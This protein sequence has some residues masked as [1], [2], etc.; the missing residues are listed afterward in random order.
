MYRYVLCAWENIYVR[1][2]YGLLLF[3]CGRMLFTNDIWGSG[4]AVIGLTLLFLL[5]FGLPT[6]VAYNAT[7]AHL[8]KHNVVSPLDIDIRIIVS[9]FT[10]GYCV[11]RG[12]MLAVVH[13]FN[14]VE[15]ARPD[16]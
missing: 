2:S 8:E 7:R 4:S 15:K 1:M 16:P 6:F 3:G 13:H 10:A 14:A 12:F 9:M 5:K 11:E